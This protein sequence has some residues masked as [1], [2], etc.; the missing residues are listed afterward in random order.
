M[1]SNSPNSKPHRH[2]IAYYSN[3]FTPMEQNY[4]IYEREFLGVVKALEHWRQYLIWT[5]QPFIIET[6]HENLMYW[7]APRKLTGRMAQ[8]HKKLQDYNFKIIHISGKTNTPA[9]ALSRPS[10]QDIQESTK[11]TSLIPPE[12]FLRIFGP[13][14]DDSL[15]SRIVEGQKR[16]QRT[17]GE[18]AKNL[19]IH[20]LDGETSTR[21]GDIGEGTR[22]S[23]RSTATTSGHEQGPGWN[24]T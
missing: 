10:R 9:N 7:K 17:M 2:P 1:T 4:D 18:W 24:S 14:L 13:D 21:E 5:K 15:E 12:V 19:P 23:D 20:E 3:T 6:D 16:H 22:Q 11:E 8:W